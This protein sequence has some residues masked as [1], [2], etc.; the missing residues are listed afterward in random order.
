MA[1]IFINIFKNVMN[2][3]IVHF[4]LVSG[5]KR[6]FVIGIKIAPTTNMQLEKI[7]SQRT[8]ASVIAKLG[9]SARN[10]YPHFI[11]VKA[12]FKFG[13]FYRKSGKGKTRKLF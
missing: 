6:L 10:T 3:K 8:M 9:I 2:F 4:T 13:G 11:S 12:D 7:N 5:K 1:E